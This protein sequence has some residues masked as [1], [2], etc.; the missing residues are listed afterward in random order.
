[1][2]TGK[3]SRTADHPTGIR[4]GQ[5]TNRAMAASGNRGRRVNLRVAVDGSTIIRSAPLVHNA[6]GLCPSRLQRNPQVSNQCALPV[7]EN[8]GNFA[9]NVPEGDPLAVLLA[10]ADK[11][12]WLGRD[13]SGQLQDEGYDPRRRVGKEGI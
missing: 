12:G 5:T 1:M 9:S 6:S 7:G 10:A 11:I 4:E 2:T 3:K 8:F 13:I